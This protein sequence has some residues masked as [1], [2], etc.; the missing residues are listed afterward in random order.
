MYSV[1]VNEAQ[2]ELSGLLARVDAGDDVVITR[3]GKP[4]ARLVP[5]GRHNGVRRFGSMK[6]R[7]MVDDRFFDPLP[8]TELAAWES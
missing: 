8:E 7:L 2:T 4:V 3:D 6:G 5:Y 1:D